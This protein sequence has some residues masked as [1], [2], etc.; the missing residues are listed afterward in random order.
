VVREAEGR[1]SER[2]L[3]GSDAPF[4]GA[5]KV[6]SAWA[7]R[8]SPAGFRRVTRDNAVRLLGLEGSGE[9]QRGAP[10]DR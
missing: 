4:F 8:L 9:P 1:L 2:V 5:E 3:F 7:E 10:V 6:L